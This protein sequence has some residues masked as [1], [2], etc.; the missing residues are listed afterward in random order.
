MWY[1]DCVQWE[2][3]N[4]LRGNVKGKRIQKIVR[5]RLRFECYFDA[6]KFTFSFCGTNAEA[7]D[8]L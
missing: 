7:Q 2:L 6:V 3:L 4:E 1:H 5:I 8:D